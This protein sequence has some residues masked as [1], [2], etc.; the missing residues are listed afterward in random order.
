M[1][2]SDGN[3]RE[4]EEAYFDNAITS[5]RYDDGDPITSDEYFH[6]STKN[7]TSGG[8]GDHAVRSDHF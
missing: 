7:V 4:N 5:L 1:R 3:T 2:F 8:G 6:L